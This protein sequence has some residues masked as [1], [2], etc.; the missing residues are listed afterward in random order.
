MFNII[1]KTGTQD[2]K[3]FTQDGYGELSSLEEKATRFKTDSFKKY[4]ELLPVNQAAS[5]TF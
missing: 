5:L 3:S 2:R 1:V 4:F